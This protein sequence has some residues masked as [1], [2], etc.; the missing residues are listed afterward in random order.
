VLLK[1]AVAARRYEGIV[2]QAATT[3]TSNNRC[4]FDN[5][6]PTSR[7]MSQSLTES[8]A[9]DVSPIITL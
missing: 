2:A 9:F 5:D 3:F 7:K 8:T 4:H 1:L 6:P